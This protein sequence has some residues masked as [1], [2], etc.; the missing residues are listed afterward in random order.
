[1]ITT[2]GIMDEL[3]SYTHKKYRHNENRSLS[4]K[5]FTQKYADSGGKRGKVKNISGNPGRVPRLY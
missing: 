2:Q 1:M 5:N 3:D 4:E